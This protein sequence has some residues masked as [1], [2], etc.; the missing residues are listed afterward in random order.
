MGE[1]SLSSRLT[2]NAAG[3]DLGVHF[4][5]LVKSAYAF[6]NALR[7]VACREIELAPSDAYDRENTSATADI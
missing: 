4:R 6:Q 2:P 3:C 7:R 5:V 1:F